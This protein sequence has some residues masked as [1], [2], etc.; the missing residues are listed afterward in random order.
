MLLAVAR[1]I[2]FILTLSVFVPW[3]VRLPPDDL[4]L[5]WM[6][7]LEW[8][9]VHAVQFGPQIVYTFGPWGFTLGGHA[10]TIFPWVVGVW[11][12]LGIAFFM[13]I[14]KLAETVSKNPWLGVLWMF[15]AILVGGGAYTQM[16]DVRLFAM[17][18]LLLLLHFAV[19][20]HPWR[21]SKIIL[22]VAMA[23]S[24]LIK[25]SMVFVAAPVLAAVTIDQ[26]IRRK[27]PSYLFTFIIAFLALWMVQLQSLGNLWA[28]LHNSWRLAA[29]YVDGESVTRPTEAIDVACYVAAAGLLFAA[30]IVF[31]GGNQLYRARRYI[32]AICFLVILWITFKSG[33][34]RHDLHELLATS[35]LALLCVLSCA[36]LWPRAKAAAGRGFMVLLCGGMIWYASISAFREGGVQ[37]RQFFLDSFISFPGRAQV[38]IEWLSGAPLQAYWDADLKAAQATPVPH[39]DGTVDIYSTGQGSVLLNG[40]DYRPRPVFQSLLTYTTALSEL[41]AD[42]LRSDQAPQNILFE[43]QPIDNHYPS[44]EEAQSWPELLTRY[45]PVDASQSRLIL[46][47]SAA[48]RGYSIVPIEQTSAQFGRWILVPES[49]DPIWATVALHPT[50]GGQLT[51]LL[52][53]MPAL[54]LG[55]R[56]RSGDTEWFRLLPDVA[57]GGFL[58]SPRTWDRISFAGLYSANWKAELTK[59]DVVEMAI[60]F[61][62]NPKGYCYDDEFE[63][64]FSRL[65][66]PHLNISQVPGMADYLNLRSWFNRMTVV[67]A[68]E[69]PELAM[70]DNGKMV[71][72]A[73]APSRMIFPL[74]PG[75]KTFTVSYGM[76]A[77][78]FM[79]RDITDGVL[80]RVYTIDRMSGNQ[81]HANLAWSR[82]LDPA[83]SKSDAGI[84]KVEV[85]LPQ[86]PATVGVMLE[87]LPGPMHVR[88]WSYWTDFA[89]R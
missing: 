43:L 21:A 81:V 34:V 63:V 29:G 37:A 7:V 9:H 62:D 73:A 50:L 59:S 44:Q 51:R 71:L 68:I 55:V 39:V 65:E 86:S 78:S 79:G 64:S 6:L 16:Q 41:N 56:T 83:H 28:F 74:E 70:G 36:V 1:A 17:S 13:A 72:A 31:R 2:L 48:A 25:F 85:S 46:R 8:A 10:P 82:F 53:K 30:T 84:Q 88:S 18:W 11:T 4:D 57:A 54:V 40:D 26:I 5:S 14:S 75:A 52:Y 66:F 22:A 12:F 35:S 61:E 69:R 76:L 32:E 89:L 33:F 87:T 77:S 15:L 80:F 47:K 27:F 67:A 45:E 3:T 60:A 23:L 49:P 24:C 58:L 42:F 38:A 20:D 19:D